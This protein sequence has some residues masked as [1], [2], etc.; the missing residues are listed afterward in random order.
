[1]LYTDCIGSNLEEVWSRCF[2]LLVRVYGP[3]TM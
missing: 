2:N 1:M 3:F